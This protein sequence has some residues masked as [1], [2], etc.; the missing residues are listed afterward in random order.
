M[1]R[2]SGSAAAMAAVVIAAPAFTQ[3]QTD[4]ISPL[5]AGGVPFR[6]EME[7]VDWIGDDLPAIH[8]AAYAMLD[9]QLLLVG[10]KTSGLHNFTCDPDVNWPAADFNGALMVV[11]FKTR[12]TF[13]R[14]LADAASGLPPNQI[15]SLSSSNSLAHQSGERLVSIGG[16]GVDADGDYVTFSTLRVLDVAGVIG[17][18]R[19][20]RTQ[21]AD[22]IRF[23][24]APKDAPPDFFTI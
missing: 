15:A 10:G 20:D 13:T 22:H 4:T 19:G 11:D 14:P 3:N 12:D 2:R 7:L 9:E 16:Y 17:W 5:V 24:E 8:S 1:K 18:V 6:V 21:L 23:H